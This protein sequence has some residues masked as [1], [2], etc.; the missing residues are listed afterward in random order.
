MF[1]ALSNLAWFITVAVLSWAVLTVSGTLG[2]KLG[3]LT[4]HPKDSRPTEVAEQ[5]D[6]V[7]KNLDPERVYSHLVIFFQWN[8]NNFKVSQVFAEKFDQ[9][10][11]SD[12]FRSNPAY[13]FDYSNVDI[14][15]KLPGFFKV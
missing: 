5:R 4:G 7:L 2:A 3:A 10:L 8:F 11:V 9:L 12:L 13:R 14:M 15:L 1:K 6:P